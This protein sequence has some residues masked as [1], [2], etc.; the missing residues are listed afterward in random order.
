VIELVPVGSVVVSSVATPLVSVPVPR[1][2]EPLRKVTEPVGETD[3]VVVAVMVAVKVT[4]CPKTGALG[5][6]VSVVVVI[7]FPTVTVVT[8]EVLDVNVLSPEYWAV[9]ELAPVARAVGGSEATPPAIVAVPSEVVPLKNWTVP[10]GVPEVIAA[11]V[12]VSVTSCPNTGALGVKETV[13]LDVADCASVTVAI[14]EVSPLKLPS[15]RYCAVIELGPA[16]RAVVEKVATPLASVTVP[17]AVAPLKNWTVPV[18]V[19]DP[20]LAALTVAVS[21]TFWP[22][23]GDAGEN[24]T[25]LDEA[26]CTTVTVVGDEVLDV[27][28]SSPE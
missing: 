21:V 25:T 22:T 6:N 27:K 15:P 19:P 14:G 11:T 3:P 18:G 17:I 2:V 1:V 9:I 24:V 23:T 13:V 10:V 16:A 8:G 28:L 12:A 4:L 7:A 20:G 26:D 5:V